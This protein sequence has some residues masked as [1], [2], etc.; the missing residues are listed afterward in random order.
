MVPVRETRTGA[1]V[2]FLWTRTKAK[3]SFFYLLNTTDNRGY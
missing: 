1:F 2:Y 3:Q